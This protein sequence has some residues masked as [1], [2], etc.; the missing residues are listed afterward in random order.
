M[1]PNPVR[2]VRDAFTL[3]ELLVVIAIIAVLIALLLPAVQAAREAARRAQCVNNLKQMGL[4]IHN[5][6]S[7]VGTL[8][9]GGVTYSNRNFNSPCD[10]A[11]MTGDKQTSFFCL[12]LP[13]ME[14]QQVANAFNFDFP[15]AGAWGPSHGGRVNATSLLTAI[16]SYIC[17]SD[18]QQTP[19]PVPA[20]S[21]NGYQQCS[22]AANAGTWN[23]LGYAYGCAVQG[24][25]NYPGRIEYPGNGPFDKS[26]AYREADVWDG[27]SNTIFAG[28]YSRYV[29]DPV[30]WMNQWGR[31]QAFILGSP[32]SFAAR[33][34]TMACTLPRINANL[35]IP[36]LPG[37]ELPDGTADDSDYKAWTLD[38]ARYKEIGNFGFHGQHPGGANFL[39][40]GGSVK[41]LKQTIDQRTYMGLGTRASGEAIGADAY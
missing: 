27:L 15:T 41:F 14:Q 12:I 28:E 1:R 24:N 37:A 39:F 16:S 10:A 11:T 29:N 7:A 36:C 19:P 32:G 34:Q 6:L 20:S 30:S 38:P 25:V 26:T 17:P 9:M 8:P 21:Q 13:Y 3:I 18:L 40:G 33:G 22:Y 23:V 31:L 4:A 5:Y 35:K 2:P